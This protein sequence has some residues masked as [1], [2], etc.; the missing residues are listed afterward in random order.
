MSEDRKVLPTTDAWLVDEGG[1]AGTIDYNN[2]SA[3]VPPQ[4]CAGWYRP[5]GQSLTR[6]L[7]SL[8]YRHCPLDCRASIQD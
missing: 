6:G 7:V 8:G 4:A 3:P 1:A 5:L 2:A